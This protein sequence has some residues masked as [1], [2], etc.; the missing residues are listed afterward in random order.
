MAR[1]IEFAKEVAT[2]TAK[3]QD[4]EIMFPKYVNWLDNV[5]NGKPRV[6]LMQQFGAAGERLD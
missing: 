4:P 3:L 1:E 2:W 5:Y 6:A